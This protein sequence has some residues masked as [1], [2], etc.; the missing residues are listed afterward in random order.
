[1]LAA[2]RVVLARR[3]DVRLS[4]VTGG[5][6][7]AYQAQALELGVRDAIDIVRPP[8]DEEPSLLG[9]ADIALN[10]RMDCDG[11]PMK[12]LNYMAAARPVVSFAGSAPGLTHRHTAW[13]V[14]DGDVEAFASGVLAL[15]DDAE[16]RSRLGAN[17]RQFV[18]ANHSWDRS[19]A[20][21]EGLYARLVARD[22]AGVR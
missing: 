7:D 17:A 22:G 19:A 10:P 1:M 21:A 14:P 6:F 12:L 16:L 5:E 3:P 11:I 13:L 15:L 8:V 4:I 2:M 20:L 9:A 18:R